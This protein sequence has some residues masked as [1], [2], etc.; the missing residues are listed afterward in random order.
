MIGPYRIYGTNESFT[1][2]FVPKLRNGTDIADMAHVLLTNITHKNKRQVLEN[3]IIPM[4]SARE[5]VNNGGSRMLGPRKE[6]NPLDIR[7]R[8]TAVVDT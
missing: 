4:E 3:K 7:Y 5:S 1:K 6:L 2:L 8:S